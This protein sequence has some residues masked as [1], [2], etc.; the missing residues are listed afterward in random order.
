MDPLPLSG[1]VVAS[2]LSASEHPLLPGCETHRSGEIGR[3][4]AA[5]LCDF[6]DWQ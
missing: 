2:G 3:G 5:R 6:T 4:V 1:Q